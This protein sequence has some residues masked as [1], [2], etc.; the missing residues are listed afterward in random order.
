[1]LLFK[2]AENMST[3]LNLDFEKQLPPVNPLP[4]PSIIDNELTFEIC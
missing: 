2:I 1:M 3:I 4:P